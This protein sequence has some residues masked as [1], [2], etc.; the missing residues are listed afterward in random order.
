[1]MTIDD[2]VIK[3]AIAI[4]K[5]IEHLGLSTHTY[6]A[7]RRWRIYSI[8]D[9]MDCRQKGKLERVRGVG[10]KTLLEIDFMIDKYLKDND[11]W[12]DNNDI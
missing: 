9:L 4:S 6:N 7:M 5:P 10:K 1:M 12:E 11:L 2:R 3:T 8:A